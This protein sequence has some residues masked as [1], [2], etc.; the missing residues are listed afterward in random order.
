MKLPSARCLSLGG[1]TAL[2]AC[3]TPISFE[4]QIE[5]EEEEDA[6]F[7]A[8]APRDAGPDARADASADARAPTPDASSPPRDGGFACDVYGKGTSCPATA[9]SANA[10]CMVAPAMAAC[11]YQGSTPGMLTVTACLPRPP[12]AL[13]SL[14][15]A[16]CSYQC[17]SALP[18]GNNFF[19]LLTD[20]CAR[21]PITKCQRPE[22]GISTSQQSVDRMLFDAQ[23]ACAVPESIS[24]GVTFDKLGCPD[25][26]YYTA[27]RRLPNRQTT[28]LSER[29]EALRV[30]CAPT[31]ALSRQ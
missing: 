31:C 18:Q 16:V 7:D 3:S 4:P 29:L 14:T 23:Q 11:F 15:T 17:D 1:L 26:L 27:G 28:C 5:D 2:L 6:S 24:L 9:P 21:R 10:A 8:S 25:W 22:L 12:T 19:S 13:W 30:D 20:D